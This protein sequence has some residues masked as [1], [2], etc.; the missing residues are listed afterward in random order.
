MQRLTDQ[1]D[2]RDIWTLVGMYAG[3][4]D[5]EARLVAKYTE[6]GKADLIQA[7]GVSPFNNP[8]LL[9]WAQYNDTKMMDTINKFPDP[10]GAERWRTT[11]RPKGAGG[12]T[13]IGF[14][15]WSE[16]LALLGR[17]HLIPQIKN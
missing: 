1:Q 17:S 10:N 8:I 16:M 6:K 13:N 7:Y 9:S 2:L 14:S 15:S 12:P 3:H 4:G 5:A 11:P